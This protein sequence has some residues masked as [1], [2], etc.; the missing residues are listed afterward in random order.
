MSDALEVRYPDPAEEPLTIGG[1]FVWLLTNPW[2]SLVRRWN[3]KSA[4]FSAA[5]RALLF[6]LTNLRAGL[7]AATAAMITEAVFRFCTSGFYGALTQAFRRA[8]PRWAATLSALV[9]LPAVSHGLEAFVHWLRGTPELLLS[10]AASVG[11]TMVS[12]GFTL[13]AMRR[14]ALVVGRTAPS[15]FADMR[16]FPRLVVDFVLLLFRSIRKT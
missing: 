4:T 16:M 3:Y 10:V 8:E 13:F 2:Q 14:G 9:L 7:D 11:M 15:I 6:L 5:A 1:V 12:T